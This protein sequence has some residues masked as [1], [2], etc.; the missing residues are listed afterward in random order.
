MNTDDYRKR[1]GIGFSDEEKFNVLKTSICSMMKTIADGFTNE[2]AAYA[3]PAYFISVGEFYSY[4]FLN[5]VISSINS[6]KSLPELIYK[7]S[8]FKDIAIKIYKNKETK[9]L[10]KKFLANRMN[11]LNIPYEIVKDKEGEFIIP[12]GAKE[13]DD[14]LVSDVLE[15]L[16]EYPQTRKTY[17]IALRQYANGENPRD[18]ADNLRKA[19]EE[20]LQE[21]LENNRNLENNKSEIKTYLASKG[22]DAEYI[23]IYHQL[24]GTYKTINDMYAK[25][26]D[27]TDQSILEFL[28]YQTGVLMRTA[29][30][31][32]KS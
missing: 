28:L 31:V 26:H 17:T 30:V 7:Y 27:K 32:S 14:A 10:L 21:L 1:L 22:V 5:D 6:A 25:H 16:N 18:V 13:L 15:W 8:T 3:F 29:I 11:E 2:I 20:F 23:G 24:I 19:F 9:A 12:K 4:A